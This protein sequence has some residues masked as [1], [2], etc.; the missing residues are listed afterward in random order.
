M[1]KATQL[2]SA[3]RASTSALAAISP[4]ETVIW[5]AVLAAF[6]AILFP[7]VLNLPMQLWPWSW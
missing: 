7:Y 6:S 4:I 5:G 3:V 2:T 1:A